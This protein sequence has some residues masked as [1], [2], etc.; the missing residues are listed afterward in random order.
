[1]DV[2]LPTLIEASVE[3]GPAVGIVFREHKHYAARSFG[4]QAGAVSSVVS[5]KW[6]KTMMRWLFFLLLP[7][8]RKAADTAQGPFSASPDFSQR[9]W[10]K[11]AFSGINIFATRC[12]SQGGDGFRHDR[13]YPIPIAVR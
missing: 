1:M 5:S 4:L 11:S 3:V 7:H 12:F 13:V 9:V 2:K 8:T 6:Q 10:Q